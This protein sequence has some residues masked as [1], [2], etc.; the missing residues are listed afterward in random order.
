MAKKKKN[1]NEIIKM[2]GYKYE[3]VNKTI[4]CLKPLGNEHGSILYVD[5]L[6]YLVRII[7]QDDS[8]FSTILSLASY[9]DAKEYPASEK[10]VKLIEHFLD[11]WRDK[12]VLDA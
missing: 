8:S 12:G 2:N 11:F 6:K 3:I 9:L 10:Q 5:L 7:P 1:D 4:S